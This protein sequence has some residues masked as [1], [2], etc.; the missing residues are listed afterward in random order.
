[1]SSRNIL[2]NARRVIAIE[3]DAV[4]SL[5]SRIDAD[6][7]KAVQLLASCKGRIIVTGMGKSGNIGQKF[8]ATL[9]STGTPAM[10]LHPSDAM[11]GDLGM[12]QRSD[13]VVAISKSGDTPEL[14]LLL[15]SL[16]SIP[17]KTIALVGNLKSVLSRG[18]TV[19]LDVS[20]K[21]EACP[22]NLAPTASTTAALVM[23]DALA[24]ALLQEKKFTSVDFASVHPGGQLG[25]QLLM[26]VDE[27]MVHGTALPV[28][29]ENASIQQAIITISGKRLGATCVV[30]ESKKL[31][32]VVTDGDLRRFLQRTTNLTKVSAQDVM[33]R[34]PKTTVATTHAGTALELMERHSIMQ[35][36]VIDQRSRPIGMIHL[37]DLVKAGFIPSPSLDFE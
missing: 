27:L 10:Y 3:L 31:V 25:R 9:N 14:Q 23:C 19:A 20:V 4:K 8:V 18:A 24:V 2:V 32:G 5:A 35:L 16:K 30:D 13:V 33:T 21:N 28:V 12:V 37:H 6:F 1:M 29:R 26:T 15:P 11:H 17:V 22:M 36:I 7:V 34:K